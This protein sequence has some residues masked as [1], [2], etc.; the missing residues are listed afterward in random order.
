MNRPQR[1][2]TR[3]D[4]KPLIVIPM[5]VYLNVAPQAGYEATGSVNPPVNGALNQSKGTQPVGATPFNAAP[6]CETCQSVRPSN[7]QIHGAVA[8]PVQGVTGDGKAFVCP[9][10]PKWPVLE[11][12]WMLT[13]ERR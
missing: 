8:A 12:C 7:D 5:M 9:P 2:R 6:L 1:E 4:W 11:F 13:D 3:W 10:N